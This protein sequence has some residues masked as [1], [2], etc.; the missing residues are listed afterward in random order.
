MNI[1]LPHWNFV[2]AIALLT[3][4]GCATTG[5]NLPP[6]SRLMEPGPGVGGPG[7]GVIPA[8]PA[9][10]APIAA[11]M[12]QQAFQAQPSRYSLPR[13]NRCRCNGTSP[14]SAR[15]TRS[16]DRSGA[17]QLPGLVPPEADQYPGSRQ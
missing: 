11:I 5:H 15:T 8:A 6:A 10:M 2:I 7:P 16:A 12:E 13:P 1:R 14:A 9:V 4:V 17:G 3:M